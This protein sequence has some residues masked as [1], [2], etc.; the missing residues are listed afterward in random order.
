[1]SFSPDWL[2]LREP[3]DARARNG[4]VA[5]A[6]AAHFALRDSIRVVDL[7]CGAGSNL[8][9]T[10]PLLPDRQSWTLVDYDSR[11]LAAARVALIGWA[12]EAH[13]RDAGVLELRAAGRRIHV[14]F[15]EID[16]A[17]DLERA[18]D[19]KPDLV[20]AA[21]LF[22]LASPEFIRR[23]AQATARIRAVFY[24]VLT[25]NGIQH[26]QPRQPSDGQMTQAFNRHQMSD[27]GFG[28]SAGPT[29]PVELAEQLELAGYSVIE[30]QSPWRLTAH[31][32]ARLIGE[33]V[34][35]QAAAVRE[36]RA[37]DAAT[38]DRWEAVTRTGAEVGH[39]D[40]LGLPPPGFDDEDNEGDSG[41]L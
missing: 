7:G 17:R 38:V 8:R 6:L 26:W 18:L 14:E 22:D 19:G 20:T 36:T 2:A 28:A 1:M 5:S 37:V 3:A 12:D 24:T 10:A 33:L 9:A 35:G 39:V 34:E 27:K 13:E 32:E 41:E 4:E 15:L 31:Q 21:A 11:L 23:A 25:Y 29:A 40:T 16:L 30:G